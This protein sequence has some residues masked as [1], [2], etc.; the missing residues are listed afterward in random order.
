MKWV[1]DST[2]ARDTRCFVVV[3]FSSFICLFFPLASAPRSS[4]LN[5]NHFHFV[6]MTK[7]VPYLSPRWD[8]FANNDPSSMM[9]ASHM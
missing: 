9:D 8:A 7:S 3:L 1:T 5:L 6:E 2:P 4:Q